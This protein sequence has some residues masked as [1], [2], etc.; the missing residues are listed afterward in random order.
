M[1]ELKHVYYEKRSKVLLKNLNKR[2]FE[3][4]YCVNKEKALE[5]AL[6]E[7]GFANDK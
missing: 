6:I 3:A 4:Y 7:G 2:N 1:D 5:K